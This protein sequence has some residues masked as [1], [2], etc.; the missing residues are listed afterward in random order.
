MHQQRWPN[1][2]THPVIGTLLVLSGATDEAHRER[3]GARH[4]D[5]KG[6]KRGE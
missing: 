2:V 5:D 6:A 4:G 1:Q 3:A